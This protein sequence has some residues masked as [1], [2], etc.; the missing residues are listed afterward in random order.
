M[1]H[2]LRIALAGLA[3]LVIAGCIGATPRDDFEAEVR[4][5]GG[6]L[7]DT[8][9]TDALE[10]I[11]VD[12]GAAGWE[13]LQVLSM[14]ASPGNRSV[15]AVV[16]DPSQLDFVDTISVREGEI[17]ASTPMQDADD[18]PLDELVI[19]LGTVAIDDIERIRTEALTAFG[20]EDAFVSR[21]TVVRLGTD[22]VVSVDV[23][24]DRRSAT[25][26]FG[27]E[28]DLRGIE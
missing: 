25:A 23:E 5:R 8:F 6:G 16:R 3:A 24:S 28:G 22:V 11:A 2:L 7:T 13:D 9:L 12:I 26:T 21:I 20:Q 4:A 15:T 14:S 17:V 18:L 27:A 19:Q 10:V 1:R